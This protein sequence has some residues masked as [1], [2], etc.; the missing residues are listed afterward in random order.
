MSTRGARPY[1]HLPLLQ[2]LEKQSS[3]LPQ[4]LSGGQLGAHIGAA[5][6]FATQRCEPQ[7]AAAPH[8]VPSAQG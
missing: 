2:C 7:S 8:G 1:M 4:A 3:S 5:Q 6:R